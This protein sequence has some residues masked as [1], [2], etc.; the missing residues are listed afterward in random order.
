MEKKKSVCIV[1]TSQVDNYG[2]VLQGAA[3]V[4]VLKEFCDAKT[5]DFECEGLRKSNVIA[6]SSKLKTAIVHLLYRKYFHLIKKRHKSF[7]QFRIK[8]LCRTKHYLEQELYR[9]KDLEK[10][11]DFFI[12]GSD[13]TFNQ[14]IFGDSHIGFL[15]FVSNPDKKK[16][17]AASLGSSEIPNSSKL[18][19]DKYI[20]QFSSL[21]IR[22]FSGQKAIEKEYGL[23][24]VAAIDP[25]FLLSQDEWLNL[26]GTNFAVPPEPYI[27]VYS[28]GIDINAEIAIKE[29]AK[30]RN[31][32]IINVFSGRNLQG[33]KSFG[34]EICPTPEEFIGLIKNA[35]YVYAKSFHG[36]ALS[37]LFNVPYFY[38]CDYKDSTFIRISDLQDKL[39]LPNRSILGGKLID[40]EIDWS[41]INE[42]IYYWR[43]FSMYSLLESLGLTDAAKVF[44]EGL[45]LIKKNKNF[46]ISVVG[47]T[48]VGCENCR[49]KCPEKA[50]SFE[51]DEEGFRY[52][53]IFKDKCI[54]CGLCV[55][56]CPAIKFRGIGLGSECFA[57]SAKKES[58]LFKSTSGGLARLIYKKY[59]SL[60][61]RCFGVRWLPE[62]AGCEYFEIVHESDIDAASKS[63][64][65][66][67]RKGDIFKKIKKYAA[68]G[69][70]VLF[71]GTPCECAALTLYLGTLKKQAILID[72]ICHG[73][74]SDIV[75]SD[76]IKEK[77]SKGKLKY[78][79][80][81]DKDGMGNAFLVTTQCGETKQREYGPKTSFGIGF[82]HIVRPS[83]SNCHYRSGDLTIGDF[84]GLSQKSL[85]YNKLGV[86]LAIPNNQQGKLILDLI[87]DDI[88][89]VPENIHTAV[90]GNATLLRPNKHPNMRKQLLDKIVESGDKRPIKF[91][92][93]TCLPFKSRLKR[94]LPARVK[95]ILKSIAAAKMI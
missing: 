64:Y 77:S 92:W 58:D 61:Y 26:P 53:H 37:V 94:I 91:L 32:R 30:K 22:E 54:N 24:T 55:K 15:D 21:L 52:P 67:A 69:E 73:P 42:K 48:C 18:I 44:G 95:K 36:V 27:L 45:A 56:T 33:N 88:Y 41:V 25:V 81:R 83:C 16:T 2:A 38:S 89:I 76:F 23:K 7:D 13:Q 62:Y 39:C 3:L 29:F 20:S 70:K 17:Y 84:W 50:I 63:K 60:G 80:L 1:S 59:L 79:C 10:Q 66:Q 71:I 57:V 93:K 9:D 34:K 4:N 12:S 51:I 47:A 43:N 90:K 87:K 28:I 31:L 40:S 86:S 68:G 65:V 49:I 6:A 82:Y 35:S 5:L 75:L 72:L 14:H 11:F 74:T 85:G 8:Y 46:N 19:F 78:L